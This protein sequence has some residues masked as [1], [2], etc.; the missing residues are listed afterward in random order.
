MFTTPK[1]NAS[2][3]SRNSLRV[4]LRNVHNAEKKT[5]RLS[6]AIHPVYRRSEFHQRAGARYNK[7]TLESIHPRRELRQRTNLSRFHLV[8]PNRSGGGRRGSS[9]GGS[10]CAIF[11]IVGPRCP[12]HRG[13]ISRGVEGGAVWRNLLPALRGSGHLRVRSYARK[14]Q[15]FK[16]RRMTS[17]RSSTCCCRIHF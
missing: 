1:N 2:P 14:V 4:F 5:P 10:S 11:A 9:S 13:R 12:S 16:V 15:M 7:Q 6:V 8:P 17:C 3:V